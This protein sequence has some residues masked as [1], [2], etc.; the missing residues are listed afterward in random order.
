MD[1]KMDQKTAVSLVTYINQLHKGNTNRELFEYHRC[2]LENCS[3]EEVNFAIDNLII[4]YK[5]VESLEKT[6]SRFIRACGKGLD[7]Q[8]IQ[9][10]ESGIFDVLI[11]ENRKIEKQL[12]RLKGAYKNILA[13]VKE[14]KVYSGFCYGKY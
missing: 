2:A 11:T 14:D 4:R 1:G 9:L 12:E 13:S 3:A 8:N 6:V 5:D 10:P 7:N